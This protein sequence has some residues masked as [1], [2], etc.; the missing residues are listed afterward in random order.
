MID[1]KPGTE[2]QPFKD[3]KII[4]TMVDRETKSTEGDMT[5]LPMLRCKSCEAD[6]AT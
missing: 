1:I 6:D 2:F 4:C 3:P 5:S